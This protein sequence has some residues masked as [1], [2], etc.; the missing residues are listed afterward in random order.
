MDVC[1]R[2][3]V[4]PADESGLLVG[5]CVVRVCVLLRAWVL[6]CVLDRVCSW[7]RMS[8]AWAVMCECVRGSGCGP[9]RF[10]Y[11]VPKS[12]VIIFQADN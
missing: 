3:R 2:V 8:W 5:V 11:Q 7:V 10:N 6:A 4:V 12:P 1:A 9:E